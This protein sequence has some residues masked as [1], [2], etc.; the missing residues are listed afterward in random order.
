M[1]SA[2]IPAP[3]PSLVLGSWASSKRNLT[4]LSPDQRDLKISL[5]IHGDSVTVHMVQR[6]CAV[7]SWRSCSPVKGRKRRRNQM[8]KGHHCPPERKWHMSRVSPCEVSG[9]CVHAQS[10]SCVQLLLVPWTVAHQTPLSTGFPRQGYWSGLPFPSPS[11]GI[12]PTSPALTGGFFTTEPLGKPR[13][14]LY[15]I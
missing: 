3:L 2:N 9:A 4:V 7:W 8:V 11:P 14:I 12:N 6:I 10:L 15:V 1:Q 13:Y 5:L